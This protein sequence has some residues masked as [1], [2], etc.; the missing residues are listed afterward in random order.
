MGHQ[1]KRREPDTPVEKPRRAPV[2]KPG[3][4]ADLQRLSSESRL[5]L[6][7]LQRDVGNRA[8]TLV[9]RQQQA[10]AVDVL[11]LLVRLARAARAGSSG[12]DFAAAVHG[13]RAAF[14]AGLSALAPGDP[15][16]PDLKTAMAALALWSSDPG[17]G[18]SEGIWGSRELILSVA[19]Y[20]TLPA[21]RSRCDAYLAEMLHST[22]ER[23]FRVYESEEQQDRYFPSSAREWGDP[24]QTIPDFPVV[25][26]PMLGDVVSTGGHVGVY[27]GS[28]AGRILYLSAGGDVV[29]RGSGGG[30]VQITYGP[31]HSNV[32][33]RRYRP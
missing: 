19:D 2:A 20:A 26:S 6:W 18:W 1:R 13:L 32:V 30:G 7:S 3:E 9:A 31:S 16:P 28:Y 11:T 24:A 22:T 8:A 15:L 21:G 4:G 23:V 10:P 29:R 14:R 27:L 25:T 5:Y 12:P 17:N 33:Y